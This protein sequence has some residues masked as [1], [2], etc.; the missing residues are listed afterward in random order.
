[1][2]LLFSLLLSVF[3]CFVIKA[4][5][6]S[7]EKAYAFKITSY[8]V[9]LKDST[10]AVQVIKPAS[11]PLT[12]RDQ[13]AAILYHCY[14]E[15]KKLDTTIK[16]WGR[17][18]L[19]KGDYYYFAI[20]HTNQQPPA[21]GDLLYVRLKLP[22]VYNGLLMDVMSHAV[23]FTNVYGEPFMN[24]KAIFTNT[25]QMEHAILDSMVND[26]RFTGNAMQEQMSG[27]NQ[28][29]GSGIFK[30]MKLFDVM[31]AIKRADLELFLKYVIARPKNYAGNTWKISE[32]VATWINGGSPTVI[33]N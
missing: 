11:L 21:E 30:G 22:F 2:K 5:V 20:N 1:M 27:Q 23:A 19:I 6:N 17:C 13:Q 18:Q 8:L 4:Q 32:T 28:L 7:V 25:K 14:T 31:K 26:I 29:L 9:H 10:T 16:G 24:S 12:I 15:G 33:E 3:S